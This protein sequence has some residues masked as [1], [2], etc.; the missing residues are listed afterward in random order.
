[1][2]SHCMA[3]RCRM[4][5]IRSLKP[6]RLHVFV[7]NVPGEKLQQRWFSHQSCSSTLSTA[8]LPT[9][10]CPVLELTGSKKV[11]GGL[12]KAPGHSDQDPHWPSHHVHLYQGA[13]QGAYDKE[14]YAGSSSSSPANRRF[15]FP[16]T[17]A[18]LSLVQMNLKT[19]WL[20]SASSQ[21]AVESNTS[22]IVAP[23]TNGRL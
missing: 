22:R 16:R 23:W 11:C 3:L 7:P 1:M 17:G 15:T 9:R 21:M 20:K 8:S 10:S 6:R 2:S 4:N 19:W 12:W 18:L 13:K 5:V 14:L